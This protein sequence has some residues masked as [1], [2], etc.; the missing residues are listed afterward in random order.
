M[1]SAEMDIKVQQ[2]RDYAVMSAHDK[3]RFDRSEWIRIQAQQAPL[4]ARWREQEARIEKR[5]VI[6]MCASIAGV[7]AAIILLLVFFS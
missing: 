6:R 3:M 4:N 2:E 1:T 5:A 7:W